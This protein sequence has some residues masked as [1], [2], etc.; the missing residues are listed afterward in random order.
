MPRNGSFVLHRSYLSKESSF[1]ARRRHQAMSQEAEACNPTTGAEQLEALSID[2]R[3]RPLVA[4]NPATPADLLKRLTWDQD[5]QVRRA[6]ASNPNT[7]W[8]N[9]ERLA[10]EF[11]HEFLHNLVGLLQLMTRPEQI[12]TKEEFWDA[13][14]REAA[15]PSVWWN[16]LKSHPELGASQ[17]VRLHILNS[18]E[19][20]APFGGPQEED[21]HTFLTLLNLLMVLPVQGVPL[22]A[23]TSHTFLDYSMTTDEQ[24]IST[25]LQWRIR[26]IDN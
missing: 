9:L 17:A 24:V 7:P 4:G 2:P 22:S 21:E 6:V 15:I 8:L 14:L 16:W 3:L 19:T 10:G 1:Q 12:N 5:I 26:C 20:S 23:L 18:G 25:R 13:L 11:P